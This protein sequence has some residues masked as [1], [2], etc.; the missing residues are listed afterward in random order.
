MSTVQRALA[1][2]VLRSLRRSTIAIAICALPGVGNAQL[3]TESK[4]GGDWFDLN[5][6]TQGFPSGVGAA[7]VKGHTLKIVGGASANFL[8]VDGAIEIKLD[9]APATI[10]GSLFANVLRLGTE[11][12]GEI[13]LREGGTLWTG[14]A[15]LGSMPATT[16]VV[17]INGTPNRQGE[18]SRWTI[19]GPLG[20]GVASSL[21]LKGPG[22]GQVLLTNG[23][24]VESGQTG[25]GFGG[26]GRVDI[27][28]ATWTASN[29]FN[30]AALEAAADLRI[31]N[32]GVLRSVNGIVGE[33]SDLPDLPRRGAATASLVDRSTWANSGDLIV[34]R[35]T[36][37]TLNVLSGSVVS[38]QHA[39]IGE[40]ARGTGSVLV[41]NASWAN[42]AGLNVGHLGKG[43]LTVRN[44]GSVTVGTGA[45]IGL[46]GR[47]E[48]RVTI[49]NASWK[50]RGELRVGSG[51]AT[52]AGNQAV[53]EFIVQNGGQAESDYA[54]L[55][56]AVN[57]RGSVQVSGRNASGVASTWRAGQ[58][59]RVGNDGSGELTV[60][61]GGLVTAGDTYLGLR[62]AGRLV[63]GGTDGRRGVLETA[64]LNGGTGAGPSGAVVVFNGG[65]LRATA[66]QADFMRN[67]GA[68]D[69]AAGGAFIDSN[70]HRIGTFTAFNGAGGLTKTGLGRLALGAHSVL[71]GLVTVAQGTLAVNGTLTA[72]LQVNAGATLGGTGVVEGAVTVLAG[73]I[74]APGNSPG[75]LTLGSLLLNDGAALGIEIGA[76]SDQLVV[77]GDLTLAGW[78]DLLGDPADFA[79][80]TL[81]AFI[82][83]GGVL[84]NKGAVIRSAPAGVDIAGWTLD[85]S[86]PGVVG[87]AL[88]PVP[89]PGTSALLL[90]G[91]L[92]LAV[93]RCL[94]ARRAGR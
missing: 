13:S 87:F 32:N 94:P 15:D 65:M 85:L 67:I 68:A 25:I 39:Y 40:Q 11:G 9:D 70:G 35:F 50:N 4:G 29:V 88:Q 55:G 77:R 48:G 3:W 81:P 71:G 54:R 74:L 24:S 89:E 33:G 75:T 1:G 64:Q 36:S 14:T 49:D 80:G 27:D 42:A 61:D 7:T 52:A 28:N 72:D 56:L 34:G 86:T 78:I 19:A 79:V 2:S 59:L 37:G 45:I 62:A 44:G 23:G 92:G 83:Y 22:E 8:Y 84:T 26:A 16:G 5:N 91:M 6:W 41:D 51:F 73:G 21:G 12:T 38:N 43:E 30:L 47:A 90:L 69:V 10:A 20:I 46:G 18:R 58:E 82:T 57:A 66:D 63:L 53:G 60:A 93:R 31:S 76:V 17:R